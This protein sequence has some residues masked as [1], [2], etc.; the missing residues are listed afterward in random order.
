VV[1][2]IG[3]AFAR[4][5]AALDGRTVVGSGIKRMA[6]CPGRGH[7]RGDVHPSLSIT[8]AEGMV[9]LHCQA[10]CH[11]DDVLKALGL[12]WADLY[13]EPATAERRG[14]REQADDR[15]HQLDDAID[16]SDLP[17]SDRAVYHRRLKRADYG[18]AELPARFT[19]T[20]AEVAKA[21]GITVRQVRRSERHLE[22]HG[23]LEV[24]G[25]TGRG[26][27]PSYRLLVGKLCDCT[28]RVHAPKADTG[29]KADTLM[30]DTS[31][32]KGGHNTPLKAD[33]E[34]GHAAGQG[35]VSTERLR[36]EGEERQIQPEADLV[37]GDV[38]GPADRDSFGDWLSLISGR[39]ALV[40]SGPCVLCGRPCERYGPGGNPLCS[41]C[42][43]ARVTGA[44][45]AAMPG[46]FGSP[47]AKVCGW[48]G[49]PPGQCDCEGCAG[50]DRNGCDAEAV[51]LVVGRL[52]G[53]VIGVESAPGQG[54]ADREQEIGHLEPG[55]AKETL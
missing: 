30:A 20:Q 29:P 36:E 1:S 33:T 12:T 7:W 9:L 21:T 40:R 45:V 37:P 31:T 51:K 42:R 17:A 32:P 14:T 34:G 19:E 44:T 27:K 25:T 38:C 47:V 41:A 28:G 54:T 10:G 18:T 55:T 5:I 24:S 15:W 52:G 13:D 43:D 6:S 16:A 49:E 2:T 46:D 8:A 35:P 48:C 22:S 11:V 39:A 53:V 4:V 50:N 23:W 3:P 26:H